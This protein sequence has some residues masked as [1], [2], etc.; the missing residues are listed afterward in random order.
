MY[1]YGLSVAGVTIL[2]EADQPLTENREFSP[3]RTGAAA[4]DLHAVIR[5]TDS[6]PKFPSSPIYADLFC[7]VAKNEAGHLQTFFKDNADESYL[8]ATCHPDGRHI[9]IEYP[10]S[11]GTEI[12]NLQNCF[13]CLGFEAYLLQRNSLSL[14]AACVDTYL[15]G[16]LF[17]GVSGIGKSTQADLWCRY[18]DARLINGDRPILSGEGQRWQAWGSPYAG[19]SRVYRNESCPVSAIVLLKQ[20]K[21]CALRR[22]SPSEAFRGVW[23]GLTVRTWDAAF[24]ERASMLTVD[25]VSAVPVYEFACT[26]DE[27]AVAFL[28]EELRKEYSI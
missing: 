26:P 1:T 21:N 14:H 8:V 18:R 13:Y 16:I 11:R 19:S 17:S 10:S 5:K 22:L 23:A 12:P 24:V 25:L 7:A 15:G 28:E 3:F 27:Q 20:A 2:L 4:P 9:L 6:L